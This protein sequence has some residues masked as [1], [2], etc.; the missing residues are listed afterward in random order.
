MLARLFCE[1]GCR[2]CRGKGPLAR[3][4]TLP[5]EPL[6]FVRVA[7]PSTVTHKY[8]GIQSVAMLGTQHAATSLPG[9]PAERL[10][11]S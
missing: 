10:G 4:Q 11:S 3:R 6:G 2:D 1:T 7:T 5:F 9:L 8:H